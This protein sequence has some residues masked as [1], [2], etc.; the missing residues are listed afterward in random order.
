MNTFKNPYIGPRTF[1]KEERHLFF[2]RDREA[3]DLSALVISENLVLFYA[4]SGAGKSS[5][6]NTRLIPEL[7]QNLFEVLPVARVSGEIPIGSEVDNIYAYNL[8][9]SLIQR[10]IDPASIAGLSLSQFLAKLNEDEQG[11]F[12]DASLAAPYRN[13]PEFLTWP[14]VLI[15]DQFEEMFSTNVDAWEKRDGFFTQL[16]EAMQADPQLWVVL[17][18]RED[19][20]AALDPYAHLL[21]NGL[22]VRYYM[23]RLGR[24]A[25]IKAVQGPVEKLRPFASGVA[26]SLIDNLA[27]I[28][29]QKPGGEQGVQAGQYVEPV[30]L[31]VVCHNLWENLPSE[32]IQITSQDLSE[33]GDINESLERYYDQRVGTV[34]ETN[35]VPERLI[36][37]WFERE[38]ITSA[39]TRNLVLRD[40]RATS[41]LHDEVIQTLQGD[42]VR[43]DIRAGQ[44]WYELSHDRLIEP[45]HASNKKWFEKNLSL[46]Q[47]QAGLWVQ[48]GHSE[49]LLLRGAELQKAEEEIK[50]LVLTSSERAY[51]DSCRALKSREERDRKQR[52]T[53]VV[54]LFVSVSLFLI[55]FY[56]GFQAT[57]AK[58]VAI[59]AEATA[60]SNYGVAATAQINAEIA[61]ATAQASYADA[62]VQ[63]ENANRASN[64]AL[65][66]NLAAQ[67]N[68]IKEQ[69]H[70]LAL[71]LS[72]EAFKRE[73]NLL[74]RTTLFQLLQYSP[75]TRLFG[76]KGA[77]SSIATSQ[78]GKW[79]AVASLNQITL[80]DTESRQIVASTTDGVGIVNS[81]A[82]NA[83]GSLLAAGGCV[84]E[85]CTSN[86]QITILGMGDPNTP[87]RLIDEKRGVHTAQIKVIAFS[88]NGKYLA[89]GS[90][91]RT[92]IL[93]NV[94]DS[95]TLRLLGSPLTNAQCGQVYGL[96]FSPDG[97]V[98]ASAGDEGSIFLWD[99]SK[100]SVASLIGLAPKQHTAAIN[101]LAF[102]S[103][104][105]AKFAS[106][107]DDRTV[108]LWN[109]D[110]A[111]RTLSNPIMLQAHNGFVKS[112]AFNPD[113]TR[114]ASASFDNSVILW[115]AQSGAQIGPAFKVHKGT[116]NAV[117]FGAKSSSSIMIS[118]SNDR[119]IILWDLAT[120]LP[121]NQ[122][123][124]NASMPTD[125]GKLATSGDITATAK[126]QQIQLT[127]QSEPLTGH[128][129]IVNTLS[130]DPQPI[131]GHLLLASASD[132]Q[133]V[134]LWDVSNAAM[135]S[136]FLKLNDFESPVT[137]AYFDN[138]Q[139]VTIEGNR[140]ATK[141]IIVPE[142]WAVRACEAAQRNLTEAEWA[143][144]LPGQAY[145]KTCTNMP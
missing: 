83:D 60:Q 87:L 98:L 58:V 119:T 92:I 53:I 79:I 123:I 136:V 46:F 101:S 68:S 17:V 27:S 122:P 82:F 96:A 54:A 3:R 36:R 65:T 4:Q 124:K 52:R 55:A 24:E 126:G 109:W 47:R 57:A 66:G 33:L 31:Q 78:D 64:V 80:I 41:G 108:A 95:G 97:K 29:V 125:L 44:I 140:A 56:F 39:G 43:A 62:L 59:N 14:R 114:L 100:P 35:K 127:G 139:L 42:L 134:I 113:G 74:T 63:K 89:S 6:I 145:H 12:Y 129:G 67:A 7:E 16:A 38:L 51:L 19:L 110:A 61:Q 137:G 103:G 116:V 28:K 49:G 138:G 1:L 50:S 70:A 76:F 84:A 77:V 131:A 120:R 141:W 18:M 81:L 2:G 30:Q 143:Q 107:S 94:T 132:D 142:D 115:D 32:G 133:S 85:G 102:S 13:N 9:R 93:W 69:D 72:L 34:A 111:S 99:V 88:P 118:G 48:Q 117:T 11:Y 15:I 25:A 75:Y 135:A 130:F 106:A 105:Y 26:E 71:L 128:T 21:P 8:I 10:E 112:V 73:D 90:Y 86:G 144:Y 23:Q 121:L 5:L 37:A 40:R 20:I 104:A 22:R 91:D 45:I